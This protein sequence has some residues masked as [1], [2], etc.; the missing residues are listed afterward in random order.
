MSEATVRSPGHGLSGWIPTAERLP[1]L[2]DYGDSKSVVA[3]CVRGEAE[4]RAGVFHRRWRPRDDD[5]EEA[6][7]EYWDDGGEGLDRVEASKVAHWQPLPNPPLSPQEA[8][9]ALGVVG[10][11]DV[12]GAALGVR[13]ERR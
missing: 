1:E 3:Y 9:A 6:P 5:H 2:D 4:A 10:Y 8:A 12:I 11:S 13:T 7:D